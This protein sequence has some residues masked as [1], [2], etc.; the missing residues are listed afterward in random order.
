[1]AGA[2]RA[3]TVMASPITTRLATQWVNDG[4]ALAMLL[5]IRKESMARQELAAHRL[6][7][8]DYQAQ[9]EGFHL[10]LPLPT[11]TN[12]A[13]F[14]A[15]MRTQ[16]VG[17]VSSAAFSTDGDPPPAVR[18]SLGGPINR[19]QCDAALHLLGDALATP[20]HMH[21]RVM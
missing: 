11:G 3:T 1:V 17:V 9:P 21:T 4:T 13:D 6:A 18:V 20:P 5:A 19:D 14:A 7:G 12:V 2:L 10:W 8:F 15:H 16:G